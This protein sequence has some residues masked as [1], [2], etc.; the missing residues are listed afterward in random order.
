VD[1]IKQTTRILLLLRK[2]D[3]GL[4]RNQSQP[5]DSFSNLYNEMGSVLHLC[6]TEG[7]RPVEYPYRLNQSNKV[8]GFGQ[9]ADGI[10]SSYLSSIL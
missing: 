7:C 6:R 9:L 8:N 3:V 10:Q 5:E 4:V 1:L 2:I